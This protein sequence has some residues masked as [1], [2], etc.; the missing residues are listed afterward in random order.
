M[1]ASTLGT[2]IG[3][4]KYLLPAPGSTGPEGAKPVQCLD[5]LD[6]DSGQ[7]RRVPLTFLAHGLARHPAKPH[8]AAVF[9]KRGDGGALVDLAAGKL[10]R[11]IRA[12]QNRHFYGHAVY[13]RDGMS[14][15][16]VESALDTSAGAI[17]VRDPA[18]WKV[19]ATFPTYGDSPHDCVLVDDGKTLVVTNGGGPLGAANTL[20]T[21]APCVAYV[22]LASQK[23]VEKVVLSDPKINAGHI[24]FATDGSFALA[25]APRDG[26]TTEAPIGG[27]TVR[28]A[29]RKAERMRDPKSVTDRMVGESLSVCVHDRADGSTVA[30]VTNRAANLVTF[31][32]LRKRKLL[33]TFE[34]ESPRGVARTLDGRFLVIAYGTRAKVMFFSTET[35]KRV[36][37]GVQFEDQ[38]APLLSG[39]HIYVWERAVA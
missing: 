15:L 6:L 4:T 7:I 38:D 36:E 24:A 3:G 39:S 14:C 25:S 22:D 20:A 19:M 13:T 11:L 8:V 16:V 23:L 18:T 29:R 28:I 37:S 12:S 35:L 1:P 9:E 2:V 21:S 33:T 27:L 26:L 34:V 31:W 17:T 5:L 10:L 30:T 32:D